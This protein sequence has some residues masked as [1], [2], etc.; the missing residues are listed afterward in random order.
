MLC[1]ICNGAGKIVTIVTVARPPIDWV[2]CPSEILTC[3]ECKGT[4]YAIPQVD[5]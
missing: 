4:G 3:P 2:E 1:L 5:E